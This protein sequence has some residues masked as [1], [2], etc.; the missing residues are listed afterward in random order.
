MDDKELNEFKMWEYERK[1]EQI[2]RYGCDISKIN[3]KKAT[4]KS[5]RLVKII[6]RLGYLISTVS[7]LFVALLVI[8]TSLF[9][10]IMY[11]GL[12]NSTNVNV[13]EQLEFQ[14]DIKVKILSQE[15]EGRI[16]NGTYYLQTKNKPYIKFRA[17]KDY[18]NLSSDYLDYCYKY[19]FDSWNGSNKKYFT[20]N[21][22]FINGLLRYKLYINNYPN[23][24][25]GAKAFMDFVDFVD[26]VYPECRFKPYWQIY[27]KVDDTELYPFMSSNDTHE[28]AVE[29]IKKVYNDHIK[30][31]ENANIVSNNT[32]S[33]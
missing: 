29:R 12:S 7:V 31:M 14:Y 18:G 20:A 15:T 11:S 2:D 21:E 5:R 19:Y 25:V 4:K 28:E 10:Y 33:D 17:I 27:I 13:T 32:I 16:E 6:K 22:D 8:G 1:Q 23:I 26:E 3:V 24:D 30:A 9:L